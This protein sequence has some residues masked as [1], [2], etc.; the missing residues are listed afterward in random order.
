LNHYH[1]WERFGQVPGHE[2]RIVCFYSRSFL[3]Q[4]GIEAEIE[5]W[6]LK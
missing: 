2:E 5:K 6:S 3:L 4:T 1:P